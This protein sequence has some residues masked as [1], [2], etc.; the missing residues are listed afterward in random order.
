MSSE[1]TDDRIE[2]MRAMW[3]EGHSASEI[4]KALGNGV[5]RCAVIGKIHRV[6]IKEGSR[7]KQPNYKRRYPSRD[8]P[9]APAAS[10]VGRPVSVPTIATR[11]PHRQPEERSQPAPPSPPRHKPIYTKTDR[12]P[13][14]EPLPQPVK[15]PSQAL[16]VA[17][18][19]TEFNV[20]LQ[21]LG[22]DTCRWPLGDPH[23]AGFCFCGH[24]PVEGRPYCAYHNRMAADPKPFRSRRQLW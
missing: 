9:S 19:S 22:P 2:K 24:Q 6:E 3:K 14:R 11:S 17:P 1:W 15:R 4:A 20:S 16:V 10:T 23:E 13:R 18:P 8:A 21:E 12:S 5:T 7:P